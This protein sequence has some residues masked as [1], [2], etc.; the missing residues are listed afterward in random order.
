VDAIDYWEEKLRQL[1]MKIVN[2]RK[3]SYPAADLAFV[4][5]DSTAASQMAIQ[6][7]L[8]PVPGQLLTKAAPSP[9]D[10]VWK[11]TYKSRTVR[12]LRSWSITLLVTFLSLI[13][14]IPV[15]SVAWLVS[16]C[17]IKKLFPTFG[18]QLE[19]HEITKSLV[20]TNIPTLVVTLLNISV[21]FLYEYLS[22]RQG[23][24]SIGDVELSIVSK[25]F[26]FTFF[27]I[28][29]VFAVSGTATGFWAELSAS[30]KDTTHILPILAKKI[31]GLNN[32][33]LNF[34]M[35]QGIGL[36]PVKLLDLGSVFDIAWKRI[37]A[38]TPRDFHAIAHPRPIFSYG[39]FS[40]HRPAG[41]S[42]LYSVQCA[43]LRLSHSLPWPRVLHT[44]LLHI[45]VSAPVRNGTTP[46]CNGWCMAYYM[47]PCDLILGHLPIHDGGYPGAQ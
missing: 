27:N 15:A 40:S 18:S 8:G 6:A 21:P 35:L 4:T 2:A 44:G 17:A 14:L 12:R 46:A 26:F 31:I 38:K 41:V 13:W 24:I 23:L 45:Q 19:Q 33:Y 32:F 25:N 11:N 28:F 10:V 39:F 22:Y 29:L 37:R 9:A 5:M 1:D 34:I 3:K 30:L 36:F 20:Q 42:A 16:L 7:L 43:T 47:L